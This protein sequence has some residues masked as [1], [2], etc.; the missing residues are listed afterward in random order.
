MSTSPSKRTAP[1]PTASAASAAPDERDRTDRDQP[2]VQPLPYDGVAS[3]A[4]GT[5]L[6]LVALLVMLPFTDDLRADGRLWWVATAA[7][8][9]GLGLAG[10]WIVVRRRGRLRA[11]EAAEAAETPENPR[12]AET[13]GQAGN[14]R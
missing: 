8:G 4:V 2:E 5:L 10:L 13:T 3:V 1:D 9:F 6:W 14:S 12:T 11:A 7:V